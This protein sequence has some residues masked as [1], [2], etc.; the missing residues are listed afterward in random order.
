MNLKSTQLHHQKTYPPVDEM[1][2]KPEFPSPR[3]FQ[4]HFEHLEGQIDET[5]HCLEQ[6]QQQITE[7]YRHI[8]LLTPDSINPKMKK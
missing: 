3:Y 5:R 6:L 4:I 1:P 8:A 7:L 2:V